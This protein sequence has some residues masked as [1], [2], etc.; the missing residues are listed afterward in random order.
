[1]REEGPDLILSDHVSTCPSQTRK[2][3][4]NSLS[5]HL[6]GFTENYSSLPPQMGGF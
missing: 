3:S 2:I 5:I 6:L 1:M 4:S